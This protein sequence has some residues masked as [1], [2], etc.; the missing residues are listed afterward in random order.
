MKKLM[1][2]TI[3]L[4][5]AMAG[6]TFATQI[7]YVDTIATGANN[8][9][10]WANAYNHLQDAL[11]VS[12]N[13]DE[14]RVAKGFYKPDLGIG[15]TLGDRTAAFQLENGVA[16]YGGFQP[17]GGQWEDR[18]PTVYETILSGDLSGND[19]LNFA[20]NDENSYHVVTGSGTGALAVLDGFT[21]TGGNA[22]GSTNPGYRGGGMYNESGSPTLVNCTFKGNSAGTGGG[23]CNSD[24]SPRLVNCTFSENSAG[25]GGG[26]HNRGNSYPILTNCMFSENSASKGGG[27]RN[28]GNYI[29]ILINCTF[30]G[31]S[32]TQ[33]GGGMYTYGTGASPQLTNCI[34]WGNSDNG[35][36]DES[37]QIHTDE[38]TPIVN[39]SCIQGWTGLL[40]GVGNIGNDPLFVT[41]LRGDYYLSQIIAGQASNSLCVDT[42]S[43]LAVNLEMGRF[44]TRTDEINDEGLVDMGYHYST[45]PNPADLNNDGMVNLVDFGIFSGDWLDV[46]CT[47]TG[48]VGYWKLDD[49]TGGTASDN[50]GSNNDAIL[51][52]DPNWTD[53]RFDGALSFD[54]DGDYVTAD[55]SDDV[56]AGDL[57]LSMWVKS[58]S[59][60]TQQF[61]A[62]FNTF[63][64]DNRLMLG[65]HAGSS[66]LEVY[67]GSWRDTSAIIINGYWHH[68]ACV[69]DDPNDK[70]TIYV[71]G[72]NVHSYTTST[73]IAADDLFS[74]G[75]EYDA[76]PS[77][78]DYFNGII[79]EVALYNRVLSVEEIQQLYQVTGDINND[80]VVNLL[81]LAILAESWLWQGGVWQINHNTLASKELERLVNEEY[82]YWQF[83][84]VDWDSLFDIYN[85]LMDEAQTYEEFAGLAAE[86][87][88]NAEDMHIRVYIGSQY[89]T[90]FT[91]S[92]EHNYNL[93]V[94]PTLVPN[95]QDKNN[96]VSTGYFSNGD[97]GY[98]WIDSWSSRNHEELDAAFQA[99]TDFN[100]TN[101]LI[102]DVR[103]N[104]GGSEDLP[105]LFAGCF[106]SEP[107]LY[108]KHRNRDISQ[109]D[110][111]GEIKERWMDPNPSHPTY[112]G[113]VVVLMGEVCMSS[114]EAFLLMMKQVTDCNLIG[115]PSYGSSGNPKPHNL[116][117]GVTV[118]LPSWLA[119][120]PDETCFE[121]EGIFPHITVEATQEELLT[122]DPVLEAALESLRGP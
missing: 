2:S 77:P 78:S 102:I 122:H 42:G 110:G 63:F 13:G 80:G 108:A 76:G 55:V 45:P 24:S 73:T 36:T 37:A 117:N 5:T 106:I 64:G 116:P 96:R 6:L 70:V 85:P 21:I 87:L 29:T 7:R 101:R 97:I 66:V 17:G 33:Y 109:P 14:I 54:G 71:D 68:I 4:L 25:D 3:V 19:G 61:I 8:G 69:L 22:N 104:S 60:T 90:V 113:K 82:S 79:D 15:I 81:D 51:I 74:L 89:F 46:G 115:V 28:A 1:C 43:D 59:T 58:D 34:F 12:S 31:N 53:G 95:W 32:A 107:K 67:D 65:H 40:G 112:V 44:T 114:C 118:D 56:A 47:E 11:S 100:G 10:S 120:R 52:G 105:K 121:G 83:R 99:L 84:G 98:I 27:I 72:N 93:N 48:L 86:L 30:T 92:V 103:A 119:L 20:N 88:A 39:Y 94:L 23:I 38:G 50:S 9:S 35:G 18:N 75:Q 49:G 41:G 26:I 57:T 16:I 111:F 91:R 62:S